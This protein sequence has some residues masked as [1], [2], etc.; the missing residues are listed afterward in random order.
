[1]KLAYKEA[2]IK[3]LNSKNIQKYK[4]HNQD[5][6]WEALTRFPNKII[7]GA[8]KQGLYYNLAKYHVEHSRI[9][10]KAIEEPAQCKKE[11]RL[12]E[13]DS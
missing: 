9:H 12:I 7:G 11:M 3:C 2:G 6:V 4:D 13:L 8:R 5:M 10:K 1:M